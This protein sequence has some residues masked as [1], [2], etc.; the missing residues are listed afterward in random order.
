M[1]DPHSSVP[2]ETHSVFGTSVCTGKPIC[3]LVFELRIG[4]SD[5]CAPRSRGSEGVLALCF[6]GNINAIGQI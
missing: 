1:P 2:L 6:L 4:G 5:H 3:G